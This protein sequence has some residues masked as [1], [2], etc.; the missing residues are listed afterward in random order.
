MEYDSG[1]ELCELDFNGRVEKLLR[2]VN[3]D[4][5][6][7]NYNRNNGI[8]RII[9]NRLNLIFPS[10]GGKKSCCPSRL[11]IKRQWYR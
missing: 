3:F 5:R 7:N 2:S 10:F 8:A 1:P 11:L 6:R 9:S 4:H